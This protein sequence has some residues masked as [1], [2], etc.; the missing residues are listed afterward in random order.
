MTS[1]RDRLQTE[2]GATWVRRAAWAVLAAAFLAFVVR[3]GSAPAD[4]YLA[5]T[6][7][8]RRPLEG[9]G[10]VAF[11]VTDPRGRMAEWCAM[12]AAD[13]AQRQ[14]GLMHQ[15]DLRGYDGMV[16][17]Y[18]EPATGG[19]WMKNTIIP[20]AVA[21]FDAEGRFISAQ[22]MDPCPPDAE[23]CPSYP[24]EAPFSFAIEVERGGLGALGIGPG[25]TVELGGS[26]CP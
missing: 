3:G 2:S 14:Q 21:F 22:G 6:E 23:V 11:T 10:E 20:L 25:S 17:R 15:E 12:L 9:F 18:D 5:E 19:F 8:G 24:A 16:F 1:F 13:D 26:P 4:P 7:A